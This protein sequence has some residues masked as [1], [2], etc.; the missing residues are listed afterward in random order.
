MT[1]NAKLK[2]ENEDLRNRIPCSRNQLKAIRGCGKALVIKT[3]GPQD[4]EPYRKYSRS[5]FSCL[6]YK[7]K[8]QFSLNSITETKEHQVDEGLAF[9]NK[10]EIPQRFLYLKPAPLCHLCDEKPGTVPADD[11]LICDDCYGFFL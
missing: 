7:Y 8:L 6:W 5:M 2:K 4:S 11:V 1:E 9:I 3:L 10:Y